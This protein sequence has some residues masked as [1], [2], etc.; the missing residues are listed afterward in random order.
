MHYK[1]SGN[2]FFILLFIFS[3]LLIQCSSKDSPHVKSTGF[4]DDFPIIKNS[5]DGNKPLFGEGGNLAKN[6]EEHQAEIA[7]FGK[8]PVVFI[9]GNGTHYSYWTEEKMYGTPFKKLL[10]QK[11][12]P[13]EAIWTFSYQGQDP[14]NPNMGRANNPKPARD[15]IEEVRQFIDAVLAYTGASKVD[16]IGHSLGCH[17]ARGYALGLTKNAP[18]FESSLRRLDKIGSMILLSGVNYGI[19]L[20]YP[21]G[22]WNSDGDL[23]TNS[24]Q[25]NFTMFDGAVNL[26]PSSIYYYAVYSKYDFPHAMYLSLGEGYPLGGV[27]NTSRLGSAPCFE[28]PENYQSM[29]SVFNYSSTNHGGLSYLTTTH[30]YLGRDAKIFEE[31]IYPNLNKNK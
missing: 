4:P 20:Q 2:K 12:Y 8:N 6:K 29:G 9:H 11:G 17:M 1:T 18:Y 3:F 28:I 22:D 21:A 31:H 27:V 25:N 5:Y 19:G 16:L 23:F 26:T 15:S 7:L 13:P 24:V 14:N 30:M 10:L